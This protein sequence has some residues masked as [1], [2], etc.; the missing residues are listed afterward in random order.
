M[1]D[2]ALVTANRL[3]VVESIIQDT[4]VAAEAISAGQAVRIDTA[5]GKFT[6]SNGSSAGEARTFGIAVKTVAAGQPVTAIK[7]GVI[8]GYDLA[9]LAYDADVFVSNTDGA[10]ADAAGTVSKVAGRVIGGGNETLGT[11]YDKLLF[12]DL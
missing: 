8:D 4:K 12:V 9:A 2:L 5:N 7:K 1:T 11:A 10:L 6:K 3:T